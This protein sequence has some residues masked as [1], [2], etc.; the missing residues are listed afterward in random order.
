MLVN[1]EKKFKVWHKELKCWGKPC[2]GKDFNELDYVIP[3]GAQ[4]V[5]FHNVYMDYAP[6][7]F[8]SEKVDL[9][10]E[11]VMEYIEIIQF[12]GLKDVHNEEIYEKYIVKFKNSWNKEVISVVEFRDGCFKVFNGNV[13]DELYRYKVEIIGNIFE[14]SELL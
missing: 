1:H 10:D 5:Y 14:H 12:A 9:L 3:L 8:S 11:H 7:V 2:I 4:Y 6:T 13:W